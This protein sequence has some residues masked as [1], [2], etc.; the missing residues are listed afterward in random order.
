MS[1]PKK[2]LEQVAKFQETARQL[3]C[4]E[5]EERFNTMLGK[6]AK[7]PAPQPPKAKPPKS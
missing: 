2:N 3:G 5:S 6:V 4:D 1:K 7:A